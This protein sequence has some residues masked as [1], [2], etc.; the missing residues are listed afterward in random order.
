MNLVNIREI[1]PRLGVSA[2][3][4]RR[5]CREGLG[6]SFPPARRL[7]GKWLIDRDRLGSWIADVSIRAGEEFRPD[8][9]DA[10]TDLIRRVIEAN[11]GAK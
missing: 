9:S 1:A 2:K 5:W 7:G 11:E 3:T 8:R 6:G 10:G 4:L